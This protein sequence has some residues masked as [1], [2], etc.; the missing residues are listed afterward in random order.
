MWDFLH[1]R[2]SVVIGS[3]FKCGF[4]SNIV[5]WLHVKDCRYGY[6][7]NKKNQ[8]PNRDHLAPSI[9]LSYVLQTFYKQ[10]WF[11][12]CQENAR[13]G[14]ILKTLKQFWNSLTPAI[15]ES[16][17]CKLISINISKS[18]FSYKLWLGKEMKGPG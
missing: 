2:T 13:N 5:S 7:Q 1:Q 3:L 16:N 6:K 17:I 14:A 15:L 8:S 18:L 11:L 9:H 12:V 10:F 4:S